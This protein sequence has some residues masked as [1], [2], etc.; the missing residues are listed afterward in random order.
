MDARSPTG[1]KRSRGG[2]EQSVILTLVVSLF[3]VMLAEVFHGA[4]PR[5]FPKQDEMRKTFAFHR[6]HPALREGVQ[7]RA[8]RRQSQALYTPRCQSLS[9]LSAELGIAVVHHIAMATQISRLL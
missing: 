9:E 6:A 7:I 4:A 2:E 8:A 5:A 3:V 1:L